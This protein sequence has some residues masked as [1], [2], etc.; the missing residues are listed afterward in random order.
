MEFRSILA[1]SS[2][3]IGI[4]LLSTPSAPLFANDTDESLEGLPTL[5]T[6]KMG[7]FR[8][9]R[10]KPKWDGVYIAEPKPSKVGKTALPKFGGDTARPFDGG[11]GGAS[12][13]L[14]FSGLR[15]PRTEMP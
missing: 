3:V 12:G 5:D 7:E 6:S 2:L 15:A 11:G 13:R 9:K 14:P 10:F 4:G 8:S 1:V